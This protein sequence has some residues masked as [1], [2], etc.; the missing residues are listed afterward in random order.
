[1]EEKILPNTKK[2]RRKLRKQIFDTMK[3]YCG[4]LLH[5]VIYIGMFSNVLS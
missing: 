1:M 4:F 5:L 2:V 3:F